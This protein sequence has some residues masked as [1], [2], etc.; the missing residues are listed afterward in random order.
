MTNGR[1]PFVPLPI[2]VVDGDVAIGIAERAREEND[3]RWVPITPD[4]AEELLNEG[5]FVRNELGVIVIP[6]TH[7][8]VERTECY[9]VVQAD[10]DIWRSHGLLRLMSVQEFEEW[11]ERPDELRRLG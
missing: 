4:F 10:P 1:W 2:E 3:T 7:G 9:C 6:R 5:V 8:Y 11:A